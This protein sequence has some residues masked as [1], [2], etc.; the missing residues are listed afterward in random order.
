MPALSLVFLLI[1]LTHTEVWVQGNAAFRAGDYDTAVVRYRELLAAG[2]DDGEVYYNLGNA[3]FRRG[4]L[5]AALAAFRA[6]QAR[7]PRNEDVAQNLRLARAQVKDAVRFPEPAAALQALFFWHYDLSW[8]ELL[9]AVAVVN[10]LLWA[11][12][13]AALYWRRRGWRWAAIALALLLAALLPSTVIRWWW[14]TTVAIVHA[15][16]LDVFSGPGEG[17]ALRFR[18]HE[19]TEASV[20]GTDGDWVRL[21]LSDGNQ[22][23]AKASDLLV[24]RL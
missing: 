10:V 18:L 24:V 12:V 23:R 14:P 3:E 19:G 1:G 4:Q 8:R 7:L 9:A 5:A 16:S 22:G 13:P 6:A 17:A 15:A 2:V 20:T 21:A 11:L